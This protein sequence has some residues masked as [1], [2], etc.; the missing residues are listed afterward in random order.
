M[1]KKTRV[2]LT[3]IFQLIS[4]SIVILAPCNPIIKII[5]F[6]VVITTSNVFLIRKLKKDEEI[7]T[8]LESLDTS[9]EL[10]L[11]K[12][13]SVYFTVDNTRKII[14]KRFHENIDKILL[15]NIFENNSIVN[16][17]ILRY[18]EQCFKD[19]KK[20][21]TTVS[22]KNTNYSSSYFSLVVHNVTRNNKDYVVVILFDITEQKNTL[23][24][25]RESETKFSH[26]ADLIPDTIAEYDMKGNILF[27][28][29]STERIFGYSRNSLKNIMQVLVEED[30]EKAVLSITSLLSQFEKNQ[31]TTTGGEYRLLNSR[32]DVVYCKIISSMR[33]NK[34]GV[35]TIVSIVSDIS[36]YKV[37]QQFLEKRLEFEKMISSISKRFLIE[38]NIQ[39]SFEEF[40]NFL[41][42][43]SITVFLNE[44]EV[45][46]TSIERSYIK[47]AGNKEEQVI[48]FKHLYSL[49]KND[50]FVFCDKYTDISEKSHNFLF[51]K[52]ETKYIISYKFDSPEYSII[53]V[54]HCLNREKMFGDTEMSAIE[55][56]SELLSAF[57]FKSILNEKI[58]E[59]Q[60]SFD[61]LIK[62]SCLG[63]ISISD[64]IITFVN[65]SALEIL[66]LNKDCINKNASSVL[67]IYPVFARLDK[68]YSKNKRHIKTRSEIEINGIKKQIIIEIKPVSL[69]E[70]NSS[71]IT[72]IYSNCNEEKYEQI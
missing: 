16:I 61:A 62:E 44:K 6:V 12:D 46:K 32:G 58:L 22:V 25:L 7:Q 43:D 38:D 40:S 71:L 50:R 9:I 60:N 45:N 63:V 39:E 4:S 31:N 33:I 53:I 28:N 23:K 72:I 17:E 70:K 48:L 1:N 30:K 14:E 41:D 54:F 42:L 18:V 27:L 56:F 65:D 21:S 57:I 68:I 36:S 47:N 67:D 34:F 29:K 59:K 20:I 51:E 8:Q 13:S 19:K 15:S 24:F 64:N 52:L 49:C 37:Q 66:E 10:L 69:D 35:K 3:E 11:K 55:I 26:F 5:F 2:L